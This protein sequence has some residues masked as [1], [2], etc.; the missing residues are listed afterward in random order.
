MQALTLRSIQ[1]QILFIASSACHLCKPACPIQAAHIVRGT[2]KVP[3][4]TK[5]QC[6]EPDRYIDSQQICTFLLQVEIHKKEINKV[7]KLVANGAKNSV[8]WFRIMLWS[9]RHRFCC[10]CAVVLAVQNKVLANLYNNLCIYLFI[11]LDLIQL[12]R[13]QVF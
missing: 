11:C 4:A 1:P 3:P 6:C 2:R 10:G 5:W 7:F 8:F 12:E 9:C 13:F